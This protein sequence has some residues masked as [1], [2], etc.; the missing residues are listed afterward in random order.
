[1]P[2]ADI[3]DHHIYYE[4]HGNGPR[5]VVLSHGFLLDHDMWAPQVPVLAKDHRVVVW[6]E[7]GHGMT[8]CHG[9]FDYWDSA[10]D[11]MGLLDAL[12][13]DKAVLVGMSQG[14]WLSLRATLNNPDRVEGL[15]FVDST[16]Q[17]L[18]PEKAE[19]FIRMAELWCTIGPVDEVSSACADVQF[20]DGFDAMVWLAKW[21]A[22]PPA[23]WSHPCNAIVTHL[24]ST[25]E[26]LDERLKSVICPSAIIHGAQDAGLPLQHAQEMTRSL[27]NFT[28]LTVVEGAGHCPPLTHPDEVN[29]A[30]QRFIEHL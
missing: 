3:N 28:E 30:L 2:F 15:M 5:T 16:T 10:S 19:G 11:L 17:P 22:R 4:V 1:M 27:P 14:G 20:V 9:P 6:D 23:S 21:R 13:T 26:T 7:R 18:P 29:A 24:R 12:G 8:D 25:D